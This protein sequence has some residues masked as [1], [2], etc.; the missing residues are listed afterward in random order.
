M[1]Q[2]GRGPGGPVS[3]HPL[4]A[5]A[6][7]RNQRAQQYDSRMSEISRGP[8]PDREA[9]AFVERRW[10]SNIVLAFII[11]AFAV[12]LFNVVR[13]AQTS[14]GRV[15]GAVVFG[16][17]LVLL[18]VGWIRM[19]RRPR[20]RL[21]ITGDAIRYV[22]PGGRVSAL[23]RESGDELAFFLQ[24]R[25]AMSR[26]W[27]LELTVKGTGTVIH[28]RGEF[29]RAAVRQVCIAHGWHFDQQHRNW[30]GQYRNDKG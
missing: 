3:R 28:L 7:P 10:Q 2:A 14:T 21:E 8:D 5:M 9:T 25:G 26:V 30:R 24:H 12:A 27:V 20:G 13:H 17:V 22:E 18:I 4:S 15:A 29:P 23:S 19:N 11:V 6:R 1:R 16:A